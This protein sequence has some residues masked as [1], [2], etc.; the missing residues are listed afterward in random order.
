MKYEV[1]REAMAALADV[2]RVGR[3]GFEDV[4]LRKKSTITSCFM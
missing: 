1:I 3:K 4:T 2:V